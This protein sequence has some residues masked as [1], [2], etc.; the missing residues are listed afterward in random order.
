MKD[1]EVLG[2]PDPARRLPQQAAGGAQ[3]QR[4][5]AREGRRDRQPG[6]PA[7]GAD[8]RRPD[9]LPAHPGEPAALGQDQRRRR[10]TTRGSSPTAGSSRS[11]SSGRRSTSSA[12]RALRGDPQLDRR[13]S[14]PPS[15]RDQVSQVSDFARL[16]R[17]N[18]ALADTLLSSVRQPIAVDKQVIAGSIPPLDTFAVAVAAAITLLF[19]TVL[20][21]S[22]IARARAGGEHLHPAHPRARQPDG[23]ADREGSARAPERPS[24]SPC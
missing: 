18:L 14:L 13:P 8:R 2:R 4:H 5:G 24:W 3:H 17:Q 22:G 19:V 16:A 1:G 12:C 23:P 15:Q 6:R 10:A 9:Q 11:R 7:Q 20:L 21:V